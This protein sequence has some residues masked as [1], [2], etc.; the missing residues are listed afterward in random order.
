MK[1]LHKRYKLKTVNT[2]LFLGIH[3]SNP[4]EDTIVLSQGQ[5]VRKL[6]S[7]HGLIDCKSPNTPL[8]RLL[9]PNPQ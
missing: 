3:I 6:I 7:R 5:Y 4:T 9:E 2:N 1:A 8:E